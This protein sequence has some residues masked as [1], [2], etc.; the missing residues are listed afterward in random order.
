M[1]TPHGLEDVSKYPDLIAELLRRGWTDHEIRGLASGNLLRILGK[2][3]AVAHG[4]RKE[5]PV[6][7][8]FDGRDDMKRR[9]HF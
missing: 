9:D 2:V 7:D 4:L 6:T 1:Q 3:E 8:I 5:K